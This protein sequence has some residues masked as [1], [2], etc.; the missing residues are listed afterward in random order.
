[1]K[2][3]HDIP[4][5]SRHEISVTGKVR[6]KTHKRIL[7]IG[8]PKNGYP[9]VGIYSDKHKK[10]VS[11]CVHHLMAMTFLGKRTKGLWI[12]FKNK[13]KQ[14]CHYKNIFYRKP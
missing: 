5:H 14:D 13:N 7:K 4:G 9:Q 11:K 2:R 1:M 3:W 6:H 8:I 12:G 10:L